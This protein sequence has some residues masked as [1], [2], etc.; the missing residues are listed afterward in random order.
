MVRLLKQRTMSSQ[1]WYSI[2]SLANAFFLIPRRSLQKVVKDSDIPSCA[3]SGL[4][5]LSIPTTVVKNQPAKQKTWVRSLLGKDPLEKKMATHSSISAWRI[6]W[7]EEP[8]GPLFMR[9]QRVRHD[10]TTK[11]QL[12][13]CARGCT[14]TLGNFAK[15]TFNP[16]SK[17]YRYLTPIYGKRQCSPSLSTRNTLTI[18]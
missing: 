8:G 18:L 2:I 12:H 11:Q 10:L 3:I 6:P 14:A 16:I 17:T 1:T 4:C 15:D 5:P 13:I 7:T 9:S